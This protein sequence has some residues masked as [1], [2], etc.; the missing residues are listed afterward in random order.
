MRRRQPHQQP[1]AIGVSY[2][3]RLGGLHRAMTRRGGE[4]ILSAG[5]LGSP[6]LLLLSGIGPSVHLSTLG[7]PVGIHHPDVGQ[8]VYDN[9]RNGISIIPS[10]PLE[11]SLIQV[12]GITPNGTFLEAASNIVTFRPR[13]RSPFLPTRTAFAYLTVASIIEKIAG[14]TSKGYIYLET[15]NVVNSP[16]VR[17]NYFSTQEDLDRCVTGV[18]KVAEVLEGKSM[19]EFRMPV[20]WSLNNDR[21]DFQFVGAGLPANRSDD[22]L[23]E[24]FCRN[25]VSTIW[26]YHGGCV[27]GKVVDGDFRVTG[28]SGLR[29]VDS[30]TLT[31]SPGTNPQA[32]LMMMG[33]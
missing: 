28:V 16:R 25:T 22:K 27:V 18:R 10:V 8:Y 26:H 33:R 12:V 3:D 19:E 21:M 1:A 30:S 11:N 5:T 24:Q 20:G 15:A 4:V 9:P 17:F 6:Q 23:M 13:R 29:V 32:T 31:V 7:I 14:P 2:R